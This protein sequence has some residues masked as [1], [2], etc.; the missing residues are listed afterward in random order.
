MSNVRDFLDL[1]NKL[2]RLLDNRYKKKGRRFPSLILRFENEDEGKRWRD[3]LEICREMRNLLAHNPRI[4]GE[5]FLIPSDALIDVLRQIISDV[6]DPPRAITI[7]TPTDKLLLCTG[8]EHVGDVIRTMEAHGYSHVPI[9]EDGVLDGVFSAGT[10]FSCFAENGGALSPKTT[11]SEF[12]RFLPPNVHRSETYHFAAPDADYWELKDEFIPKGPKH[13]RVAAVFV[14]SDGTERGKVLGMIT[15]WDM[16][17]A[18][19]E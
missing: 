1:Y 13:A 8:C 16:L 12:S 9:L 10:L 4:E 17:R 15:P 2:E 5:E 19:P 6:E 14:T 3:E 7:C 18:F 11:V